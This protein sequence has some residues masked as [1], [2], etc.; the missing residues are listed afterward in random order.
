M[1]DFI[2]SDKFYIFLKINSTA[3]SFDITNHCASAKTFTTQYENKK[4]FQKVTN[5][6]SLLNH[7][8]SS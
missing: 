7:N 3:K 2:P 4:Q 5:S 1:N 6:P 8:N